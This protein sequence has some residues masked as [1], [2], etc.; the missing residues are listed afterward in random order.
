MVTWQ[1]ITR[2]DEYQGFIL[3]IVDVSEIT[4]EQKIA[5]HA[6]STQRDFLLDSAN[7]SQSSIRGIMEVTQ[8]LLQTQIEEK[9]RVLLEMVLE[10]SRSLASF[11]ERITTDRV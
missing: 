1:P 8:Q 5:E 6:I 9:Q 4:N 11:S 3:Y 7:D 2:R 10:F